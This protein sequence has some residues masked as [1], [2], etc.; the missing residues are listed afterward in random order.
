MADDFTLG[1]ATDIAHNCAIDVTGQ[2]RELD[3]GAKLEVYSVITAEHE[4]LLKKDI[5]TNTAIG[6]PAY[7]RMIN[8]NALKDLTKQWTI[9]KLRDVIYDT[10]VPIAEADAFS[11]FREGSL[12][13]PAPQPGFTWDNL[14]VPSLVSA[15]AGFIIG[16]IVGRR[17]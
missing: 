6:L 8:A 1:Q 14:I 9:A 17:S 4:D 15:A 5:R 12:R 3:P 11:H 2:E 13:A 7:G 16:L 10:S